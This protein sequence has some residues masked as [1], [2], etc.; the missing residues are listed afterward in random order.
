MEKEYRD[1]L[2][3][4]A[5]F[6]VKKTSDRRDQRKGQ[7][8]DVDC[9]DVFDTSGKLVAQYEI[10]D[11]TGIYPPHARTVSYRAIGGTP[12]GSGPLKPIF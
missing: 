12:G 6:D 2:G 8:A 5:A 1:Q 3:I 11:S 7:D 10:H 4:D 9:Y